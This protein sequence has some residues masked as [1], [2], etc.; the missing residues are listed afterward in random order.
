MKADNELQNM[1]V[2]ASVLFGLFTFVQLD[3][4]EP[5]NQDYVDV[6][7]VLEEAVEDGVRLVSGNS[8]FCSQHPVHACVFHFF[9]LLIGQV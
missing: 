5:F 6:E 7:R 3:D 1:A 9:Q 4:E 8:A 2:F